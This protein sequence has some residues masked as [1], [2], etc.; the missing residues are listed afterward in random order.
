LTFVF[1]APF[2]GIVGLAIGIAL[3]AAIAAAWP[4]FCSRMIGGQTGDL[5]GALQALLEIA[6][7]SAFI[8]SVGP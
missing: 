2:T 4:G 1:A 7:L 6:L 8:L 5:V 3:A